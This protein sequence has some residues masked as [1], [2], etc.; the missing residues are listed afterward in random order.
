MDSRLDRVR[1]SCVSMSPGNP[2]RS[3]KHLSLREY[4]H[5][6][7]LD[8]AMPGS[9]AFPRE[10]C[11]NVLRVKRSFVGSTHSHSEATLFYRDEIFFYRSATFLQTRLP[12]G[13]FFFPSTSL[14]TSFVGFPFAGAGP[15]IDRI[16]QTK[17]PR[18]SSEW[19]IAAETRR[20]FTALSSFAV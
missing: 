20:I 11:E 15:L 17:F 5:E 8:V 19:K 6:H 10:R 1:S 13:A 9:I 3:D 4:T 16:P 14:I 12:L 18:D 2:S 7:I